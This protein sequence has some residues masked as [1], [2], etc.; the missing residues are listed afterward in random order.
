MVVLLFEEK[1]ISLMVDLMVEMEATELISS[2][3]YSFRRLTIVVFPEAVPPAIPITHTF[4]MVNSSLCKGS[5][6]FL[7]YPHERKLQV[8]FLTLPAFR[9]K[10]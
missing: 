6:L 4:P 9:S 10:L 7:L 8:V 2:L 5:K 1:N 3:K